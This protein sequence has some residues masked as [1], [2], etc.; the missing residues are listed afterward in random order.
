M[1]KLIIIIF[2]VIA[3]FM[4]LQ[5]VNAQA[6]SKKKADK[7][8][9]QWKY[10]L[11][12]AGVGTQGTYLVKVWTY[13]KNKNVAIEQCKKNAVHGIIFKGFAG[14]DKVRSGQKPLAKNPAIEKENADFFKVFFQNGG[15]YM[16]F[17]TC[18][19]DAA[20]ELIK[21]GKEYK[22]GVVV[23]V[24]VSELRKS[25]EAAGIIRSLSDGF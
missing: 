21:V 12:G 17:V 3:T 7:A 2:A 15:K 25:L 13:S 19:A 9:A 1:K 16:A 8:T 11:E 14:N 18:S 6:I 5:Q 23:S 24:N 22:A 20:N 10:E 4:V